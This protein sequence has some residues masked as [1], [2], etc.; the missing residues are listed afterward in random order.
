M[1]IY[2][3]EYKDILRNDAVSFHSIFEIMNQSIQFYK[4]EPPKEIMIKEKI[5]K[6]YE[7]KTG[8]KDSYAFNR[9]APKQKIML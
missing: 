4:P 8:K 6:I 3:K 1:T 9:L 5:W 2:S 7:L